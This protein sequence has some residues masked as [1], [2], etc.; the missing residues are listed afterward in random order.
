MI[1]VY[2]ANM[3]KK[4]YGV[5]KRDTTNKKPNIGGTICK[6]HTPAQDL[7]NPY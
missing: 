2:K 6:S 5:N 3:F 1:I 7:P 4:I